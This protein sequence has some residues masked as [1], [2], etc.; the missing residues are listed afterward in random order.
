MRRASLRPLG[1][2]LLVGIIAGLAVAAVMTFFDWRLNPE[3][4]FHDT[5]GIHWDIVVETAWSW[6]WPVALAV[7]PPLILLLYTLRRR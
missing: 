7:T 6:F 2:G 3:G 5:G 4:I 1:I